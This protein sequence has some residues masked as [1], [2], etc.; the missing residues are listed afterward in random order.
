MSGRANPPQP[1]TEE[2][3]N[4]MDECVQFLR[5]E[6]FPQVELL[7]SYVSYMTG[8]YFHRFGEKPEAKRIYAC[9]PEVDNKFDAN[10]IGVY[11]FG[12]RIAYVPK[13]L[14]A[15]VAEQFNG[16]SPQVLLVSYCT[17]YCTKRSAQCFYNLYAVP[18]VL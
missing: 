17:G 1:S 3:K 7:G 14:A 18:S 6:G 8:L 4:Y 15:R 2:F 13:D 11:S 9:L 12:K 5:A 10:A 16:L